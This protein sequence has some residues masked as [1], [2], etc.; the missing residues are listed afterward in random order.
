LLV[1]PARSL[2]SGTSSHLVAA[3]T[4]ILGHAGSC[5]A[6]RNMTDRF[7]ALS[8][9]ALLPSTSDCRSQVRFVVVF[10][11]TCRRHYVRTPRYRLSRIFTRIMRTKRYQSTRGSVSDVDSL[12][13]HAAFNIRNPNKVGP[14]RILMS[15]G[16]W[17]LSL[18]VVRFVGCRQVYS[19]YGGFL[20]GNPLHFHSPDG[21]GYRL[22]AQT[23]TT[24]DA[25]NPQG[26][27]VLD[28]VW[29]ATRSHRVVHVAS[30]CGENGKRIQDCAEAYWRTAALHAP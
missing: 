17:H 5:D 18:L 22:L 8:C 3:E 25:F 7:A 28:C 27:C 11:R 21:S 15:L 10:V 16:S 12:S 2:S 24:L 1:E 13:H 14:S 23:V 20:F 30:S 26:A 9:A 19:L 4:R 6:T 29:I